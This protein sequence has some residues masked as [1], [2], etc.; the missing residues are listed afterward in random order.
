MRVDFV[1]KHFQ[2]MVERKKLMLVHLYDLQNIA[3]IV[4]LNQSD[5]SLHF[6]RMNAKRNSIKSF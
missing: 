5:G 4:T 6:H 1:F 3:K 2:R